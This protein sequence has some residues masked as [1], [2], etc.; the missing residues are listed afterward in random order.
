MILKTVVILSQ[1]HTYDAADQLTAIKDAAGNILYSYTYD[2]N[3]NRTQ[4]SSAGITINFTYNPAN[5]L[6]AIEDAAGNIL[7]PFTYDAAG[8]T[9]YADGA[10]YEHNPQN[11]LTQADTTTGPTVRYTFDAQGRLTSRI[12]KELLF[13]DDF[14]A[15]ASAWSNSS[16]T[17][18]TPTTDAGNS[19]Y[20]GRNTTSVRSAAWRTTP[21]TDYT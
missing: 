1:A 19:V 3:G 12:T 15:G 7:S 10:N 16:S 6:T 9:I 5:Q 14:S 13:R 8:N 11:R 17:Q 2:A 21:T 18:W 20:Q 4:Q